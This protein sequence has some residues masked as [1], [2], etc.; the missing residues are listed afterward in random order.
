MT[1]RKALIKA[2]GGLGVL[3]IFPCRSNTIRAAGFEQGKPDDEAIKYPIPAYHPRAPRGGLP[4]TLA[5]GQFTRPAVRVAYRM[6]SKIRVVL[7]QLPCY[8][9]CDRSDGHTSLLDC[10]TSSHA[11]ECALCQQECIYAYLQFVRRKPV[12]RIRKYIMD[13]AWRRIDLALYSSPDRGR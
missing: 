13:G 1:R 10:Y 8:C 4:A 3:A 6:A 5:P 9:Y 12:A 7:Y 11:A 2:L